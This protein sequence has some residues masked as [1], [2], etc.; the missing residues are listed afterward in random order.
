MD[1]MRMVIAR[2]Y[3]DQPD[4]ASKARQQYLTYKNRTKGIF[5]EAGV[6]LD[7][8]NMPGHEW[9]ELYG[10]ELPELQ[11]V[12]MKVL[13]KRSSACSVERLWSFFGRVWSDERARLGPTKAVDLV[14]TGANL[15]L[16]RK[17]A[18]M[19]YEA[20]MRSWLMDPEE[21]DDEPEMNK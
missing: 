14:K 4:K 19:D 18:T 13:S 1:G 7:A 21:S 9:W 10:A 11:F 12:A 17:L 15:R 16:K 2:L 8:E 6:W 20:T 5:G 3:H